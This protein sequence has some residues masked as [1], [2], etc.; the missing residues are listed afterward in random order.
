MSLAVLLLLLLL[1]LGRLTA[2]LYSM[3]L[4]CSQLGLQWP[5][6][7]WPNFMWCMQFLVGLGAG[8]ATFV[9]QL[10][11]WTLGSIGGFSNA[12]SKLLARALQSQPAARF[13]ANLCPVFARCN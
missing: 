11:A 13:V 7:A 1:L 10:S 4:H 3:Q 9:R 8:G 6:T 12:S 2:G 5:W